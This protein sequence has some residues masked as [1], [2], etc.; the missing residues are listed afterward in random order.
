[1][2]QIGSESTQTPYGQINVQE[3]V[4]YRIRIVAGLCTVCPSQVTIENHTMLIIATDGN[5][6]APVRVDSLIMF[7]GELSIIMK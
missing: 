3:G 5:P 2:L 7:A 6:V 1:V 4:R